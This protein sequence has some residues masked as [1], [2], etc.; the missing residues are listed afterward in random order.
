MDAHIYVDMMLD[1]LRRK[2]KLLQSIRQGTEDQE[3]LLRVPELDYDR[4]RM[5]LD[6]KSSCIDQLNEID[7]GFDTLF[8]RVRKE[9]EDNREKYKEELWQ[10]QQLIKEV[11]EIGVGI[12]ALEHQNSERFQAYLSRQKKDIRDFHINHK[13]VSNYSR[14]LGDTHRPGQS[15]FFNVTK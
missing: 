7:E 3:K 12:Q 14:N 9:V 1:S 13:T 4:F 2:K 6:E 10:M 11:S 5:I 15:Y 8:R